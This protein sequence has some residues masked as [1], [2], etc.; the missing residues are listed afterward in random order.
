M[1]ER[2]YFVY[3]MARRRK[4]TL[5]VGVTNDLLR[6]VQEHREGL[7]PGFTSK[8]C[9]SLLAYFEAHEDI[10]VAISREKQIKR[11]R[12]EWKFELVEAAN[13][14]WHDLWAELSA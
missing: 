6:R 2:P 10:A 1:R 7:V 4:G 8:Y 3:I 14:S 13:P 12:R 11:W 5:Y 9:V